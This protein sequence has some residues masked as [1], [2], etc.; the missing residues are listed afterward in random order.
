MKK[1]II[2]VLALFII[3]LS[4][5][6]QT[7]KV[8]KE[9]LQVYATSFISNLKQIIDDQRLEDFIPEIVVSKQ[10]MQSYLDGEWKRKYSKSERELIA[11]ELGSPIEPLWKTITRENGYH[12][13]APYI[14]RKNMVNDEMEIHPRYVNAA[15]SDI[16]VATAEK[17]DKAYG[18]VSK[19]RLYI[20]RTK[21]V[22]D[23]NP[24]YTFE[25]AFPCILTKDHQFKLIAKT[26]RES[27]SMEIR[28]K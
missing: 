21:M 3:N 14:H 20:V 23:S 18:E 28:E 19:L 22:T 4:C 2:P 15:F 17:Y 8:S 24:V 9:E 25:L 6:A 27:A 7:R 16:S 1:I 11:K 13:T 5:I 12:I 26:K 10:E